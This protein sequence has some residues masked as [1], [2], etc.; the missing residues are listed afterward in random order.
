ST[1]R[2]LDCYG[3]RFDYARFDQ[4]TF[5][6][7][8]CPERGIF[9]ISHFAQT[10]PDPVAPVFVSLH[11]RPDPPVRVEQSW[12][13]Y[14]PGAFTVRLPADLPPRF[15]GRFNQDRFGQGHNKPELYERAVTEPPSSDPPYI[16]AWL[17]EQSS[18]VEAQIVNRVPLGWQAVALPFREPRLLTLGDEHNPAQIYLTDTGIPGFLRLQAREPGEWG[19]QIAVAARASGPAMFDF[20]V[21]YA[22]VPFENARQTVLGQPLSELTLEA[23]QPGPAGVLQAKAAGVHV[24]VVR[25]RTPE[26]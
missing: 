24:Q 16:V 20:S 26:K 19:N 14:R 23:L 8:T 15:G 22:G 5:P 3:P 2:F 7:G 17:N 21:Y 11:D 13:I 1:W 4:A 12:V 10:P 18:L 9:N 25:E 6:G